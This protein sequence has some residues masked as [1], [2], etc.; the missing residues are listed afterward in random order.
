MNLPHDRTVL[1]LI[2]FQKQ[3]TDSGLHSRL[4]ARQLRQRNAISNT[5][6]LVTAAR[7]GGVP[8]IHAPL[9]IDPKQLN[10][11]FAKLTRGRFFTAGSTRAEFTDGIHAAGDTVVH[12]RTTFDAF[13]DSDLQEVLRAVG[14]ETVVMCGF[15]TDQCVAKTFR[16][17]L[18]R[19][20]DAFVV[21]ECTATVSGY[22]QRRTERALGS[23]A[24]PFEDARATLA[25]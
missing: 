17:A 23:R 9:V 7:A 22:V 14:A 11:T 18:A 19:G 2:E 4:I 25:G 8:V 15:I 16:T 1:L 21:P 5:L 10:G 3:W 24:L 20:F 13:V 12:G 6:E